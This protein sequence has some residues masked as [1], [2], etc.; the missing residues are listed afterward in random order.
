MNYHKLRRRATTSSRVTP[1]RARQSGAGSTEL[2]VGRGFRP[3]EFEFA[4][5]AALED[6]R[7]SPTSM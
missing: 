5:R 1:R 6:D 7:W 4:A 3:F 2:A